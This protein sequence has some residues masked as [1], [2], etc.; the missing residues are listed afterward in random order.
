MDL[1][2]ASAE[3]RDTTF[4]FFVFHETGAPPRRRRYPVLDLLVKGKPSQSESQY[5]VRL[6]SPS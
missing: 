4:C 5:A 6:Q 3:E 1:Y 2:S